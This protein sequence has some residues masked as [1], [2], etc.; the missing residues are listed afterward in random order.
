MRHSGELDLPQA[1]A[2]CSNRKPEALFPAT[3]FVQKIL[4]VLGALAVR[5]ISLLR[6]SAFA[7]S[8]LRFNLFLPPQCQLNIGIF[9][10]TDAV[11]RPNS[12]KSCAVFSNRTSR[13]GKDLKPLRV[14]GAFAV[15]PLPLVGGSA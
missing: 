12:S 2:L 1:C 14:L 9:R 10:N 8:V 11:A 6:S 3:R 15:Q 13:F 5:S 4:R 7:L